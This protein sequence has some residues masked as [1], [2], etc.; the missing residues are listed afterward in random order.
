MKLATLLD[1]ISQQGYNSLATK[2]NKQKNDNR[3]SQK[4]YGAQ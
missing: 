3:T 4:N 2:I 1:M